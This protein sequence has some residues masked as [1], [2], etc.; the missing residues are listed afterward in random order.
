[1]DDASYVDV[2]AA[3]LPIDGREPKSSVDVKAKVDNS[4]NDSG[5]RAEEE[6]LAGDCA[7][8]R[9]AQPKVFDRAWPAQARST[10]HGG[11]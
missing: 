10:K 1:M 3:L 2:A 7:R 4:R 5:G 8:V 6:S 11:G 9:S